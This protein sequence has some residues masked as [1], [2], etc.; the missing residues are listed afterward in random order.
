MILIYHPQ[1]DKNRGLK[2]KFQALAQE[3]DQKEIMVAMYN[4]INECQS[5]M[6]DM[7]LPAI[8]YFRQVGKKEGKNDLADDDN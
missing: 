3:V 2:E 4:G 5:F 7:K 1:K 8:V 6:H